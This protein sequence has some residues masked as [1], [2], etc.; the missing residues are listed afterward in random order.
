[1][2]QLSSKALVDL[3]TRRTRASLGAWELSGGAEAAGDSPGPYVSAPGAA[4]SLAGE[5]ATGPRNKRGFWEIAPE[6][7][8]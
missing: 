1:M 3:V 6:G 8:W 4:A 7:G 2:R 5:A